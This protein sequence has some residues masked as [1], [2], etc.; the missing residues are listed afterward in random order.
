MHDTGDGVLLLVGSGQQR[1]REYL[2]PGLTADVPL[3]LLDEH[4]PSWQRPYLAG[5]T[6]VPPLTEERVEPDEAGLVAAAERVAGQHPVLGVCTY[7]ELLVNAT[8][9]IT[10]RLGLR[11][12][13]PRAA[14]QC[15]DKH[16][17]R[18]LL[19]EAGLP[20]P[21]FALARNLAEATAVGN[22]IGGPLVVKPRGMGASVGVIGVDDPV[23]LPG[24]FAVADHARVYGPA[25][26]A[27][28]LLVEEQVDGKEIS[29]DGA[30][31]GGVY[32][33]FC[34]ARKRLGSP[35]FF[36]ETGHLVD[37]ADPLLADAD[38]LS[39][40]AEA[41]R[42]LGV[43]DGVTHTEIRLSRKG[44]V[45]VE[46]NARLGGDLIPYLGTVAS[47]I[48]AG[49]VAARVALG[50]ELD[51]TPSRRGCA[52][53]RF[54]YPPEHCVV[55]DITLPELSAVPGLVLA[56]PMARPGDTVCLPP[57]AHV[58]RYAFVVAAADTPEECAA[59]LDAAARL[60]G[61]GYEP[62]KQTSES[63]G[64]PW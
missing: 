4:E 27:D 13:C 58:G 17:T 60:V 48:D 63:P 26:F 18:T 59:R 5:S 51:L 10:E 11:G 3:W 24:A 39:V 32:R 50:R 52:G 61:L 64:R 36:E 28:G 14:D 1:Y 7:D 21:E 54:L 6:V 41:H 40:L 2:M 19:T 15:R 29:V 47:G 16:R 43:T 42:A 30:V 22:R 55:R 33:P 44:L 8:A 34:L 35:P 9:R 57:L 62:L 53:I 25:G 49:R 31:S 20:Q 46:V 56:E 23:D 37:A 12:L 38:V 45:I